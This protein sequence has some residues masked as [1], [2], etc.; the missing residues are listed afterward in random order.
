MHKRAI[1]P[2]TK[3]A[4]ANRFIFLELPNFSPNQTFHIEFVNV[5]RQFDELYL[6]ILALVSAKPTCPKA[7]I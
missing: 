1:V 6:T 2:L 5:D 7:K 4:I 3:Q